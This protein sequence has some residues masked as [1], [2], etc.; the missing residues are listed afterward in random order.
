MYNI[1]GPSKIAAKTARRGIAQNIDSY[2]DRNRNKV[3]HHEN[4]DLDAAPKPV[5]Q[6]RFPPSGARQESASPPQHPQHDELIN[7]VHESWSAVHAELE[8]SWRSNSAEPPRTVSYYEDEPCAILQEFKP[9]D[10]ESWWGK[11]LYAHITSSGLE[12]Q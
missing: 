12:S 7:F 3:R 9:F 4:A 6:R 8:R 2:R 11:R 1:K 5:F 10:L